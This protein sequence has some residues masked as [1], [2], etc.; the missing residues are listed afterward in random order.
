MVNFGTDINDRWIGWDGLESGLRQQ[1]EVF[2][3]TK[4]TP[5]H[6]DVRVSDSGDVA[7][8][9][10]AMNIKTSFLGSPVDLECR[11]S[12]VFTKR[13]DNWLLTHFHYSVPISESTN[14]G[15]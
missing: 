1:F 15:M 13:G 3:E 12:C 8:I 7:W 10:Q 2:S 11:I 9:A 4:V 6:I 14:L 5:R